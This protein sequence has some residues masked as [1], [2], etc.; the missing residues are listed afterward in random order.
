MSQRYTSLIRACKLK[1]AGKT[2]T[3]SSLIIPADFHHSSNIIMLSKRHLLGWWHN[4]LKLPRQPSA[5][6]HRDRIREE[7]RERRLSTTPLQRLSETS[8]ILFSSSRAQ[9]DGYH[10]RIIPRSF[11]CYFLVAYL[12]MLAKYT[13]RWAFYRAAASLCKAPCRPLIREVVNPQKD[14]KLA[15]VASRHNIDPTAFQNVARQLR[16]VWPLLP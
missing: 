1:L 5:S 8:D 13:S 4:T 3:L 14:A 2:P 15:E 6:W 9:Y 12:Y 10:G 16:R 11:R 7:L